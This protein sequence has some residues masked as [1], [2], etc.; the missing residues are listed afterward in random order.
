MSNLQ[1]HWSVELESELVAHKSQIT[2]MHVSDEFHFILRYTRSYNPSYSKRTLHLL[3]TSLDSLIVLW[4]TSRLEFVRHLHPPSPSTGP[5]PTSHHCHSKETVT[6]SCISATSGD[7]A[8]VFQSGYSSRVALYTINGQLVGVHKE[9]QLTITALAMTNL[10]EGAGINCLAVGLQSG[11]VR[12]LNMWTLGVVRE[13]HPPPQLNLHE[14]VIA[15]E[16]TNESRRMYVAMAHA[17][18]M[19]L[20][21]QVGPMGGSGG[22]AG[23]SGGSPTSTSHHHG[24]QHF[25]RAT[26]LPREPLFRMLAID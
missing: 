4:D 5:S 26:K 6:L 24:Q 21:W 9:E 10:P 18:Q 1:K 13:I 3:S 19:L 7:I 2:S 22:T 20:C 12:L 23:R 17:P 15:L 16:F 14:P 8:C 25:N 11:G